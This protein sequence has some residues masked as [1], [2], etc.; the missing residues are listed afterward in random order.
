M[1]A[2]RQR[3]SKIEGGLSV[4]DFAERAIRMYCKYPEIKTADILS[5][6][7]SRE[8][9]L[10]KIP[11]K[12]KIGVWLGTLCEKCDERVYIRDVENCRRS[13]I[14]SVRFCEGCAVGHSQSVEKPIPL[15]KASEISLV[16]SSLDVSRRTARQKELDA[17]TYADYLNTEEWA[18]IRR[19]AYTREGF[20]CRICGERR[21]LSVHH[22]NCPRRGTEKPW[23]LCVLCEDCDITN[24]AA[25]RQRRERD[26]GLG[27]LGDSYH[28]V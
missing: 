14:H 8:T 10:D 24:H 11:S 3:F 12:Y 20:R 26:K 17:M 16:S 4:H 25:L 2:V 9:R 15:W 13:E 1:S 27:K 7:G 22:N 23:D 18:T 6:F 19:D 21:N 28:P 5:L